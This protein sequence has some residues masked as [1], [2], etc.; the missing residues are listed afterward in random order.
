[1][2]CF[3]PGRKKMSHLR[4][5]FPLTPNFSMLAFLHAG[6]DHK[7]STLSL[8]SR[9][10]QCSLN[11]DIFFL[12]GGSGFWHFS[13]TCT[14]RFKFKRDRAAMEFHDDSEECP[15]LP[16]F[17]QLAVFNTAALTCPCEAGESGRDPG[18]KHRE[19]AGARAGVQTVETVETKVWKLH[20]NKRKPWKP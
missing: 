14:W 11:C 3:Q 12:P 17:R 18:S 6:I 13:V 15:W 1:M 9:V 7:S 10:F 19:L 16:I 2:S 4:F 20:K 5:R 8:R